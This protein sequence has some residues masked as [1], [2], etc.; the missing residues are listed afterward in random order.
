MFLELFV[1]QTGGYSVVKIESGVARCPYDPSHN[2]T[3]IYAGQLPLL[4]RLLRR[5]QLR[6]DFGSTAI[7]L[8]IKGHYGHSDVTLAADPLA[9]VTLTRNVY[10]GRIAA[11]HTQGL[12]S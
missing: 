3:A 12:R 11:A 4:S 2:S 7:R 10:V 5:L 8:L 6:F 1:L 9:A